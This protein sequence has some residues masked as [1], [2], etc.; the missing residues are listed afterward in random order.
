MSEQ[1]RRQVFE[2][3]L[4]AQLL[5]IRST[6]RISFVSWLVALPS[7]TTFA[8]RI[9]VL[10]KTCAKKTFALLAEKAEILDTSRDACW[11]KRTTI[12]GSV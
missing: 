8:T 3:L 7:D 5:H 4:E 2:D 6:E 9:I 11:M 12:E 1:L 10:W